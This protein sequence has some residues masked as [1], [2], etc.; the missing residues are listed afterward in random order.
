MFRILLDNRQV[1]IFMI[2]RGK[3]IYQ[4]YGLGD[5]N[6]Q[7]LRKSNQRTACLL[8]IKVVDLGFKILKTTVRNILG[9]IS[10][11]KGQ[12]AS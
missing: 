9:S 11:D 7:F 10:R 5:L 3:A 8:I 1:G 6:S 4:K 2:Y 12:F